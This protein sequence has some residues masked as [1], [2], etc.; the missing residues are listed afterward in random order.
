MEGF[1]GFGQVG[2]PVSSPLPDQVAIT[3][4]VHSVETGAAMDGPGLRYLLF[5]AGCAFRC[6]YCHNPDTWKRQ[7]SQVVSVDALV[8][9][10]AKYADFLRRAGGVTVSG[11]EPLGQPRFVGELFYRIKKD[12]GLHT[13]LDTQGHLA[14]KLPDSWFDPIDLVILDI[15]HIREDRHRELTGFAL[16]PTLDCARRL[17]GLGKAM[18]I[19]Q[20][21]LPGWT[22][23]LDEA[24]ELADFVAGLKTVQRVEL[25]PFHQLGAHK[26][27]D[28][29]LR[30][31]LADAV[32]PS[33][34][35]MESLRGV[36]RLRGLE[37]Y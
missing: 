4:W 12:L 18:W 26:W 11:G 33:P 27:Q 16:Q 23:S 36:Y 24:A 21:I 19:R 35:L 13:A 15:K 5:M 29:G 20:V 9:D 10:I 31:R 17:S 30:Y 22:D 7:A 32:P 25:L 8:A 34:E 6:L 14:A 37:T 28:L 2:T 3:G 1:R